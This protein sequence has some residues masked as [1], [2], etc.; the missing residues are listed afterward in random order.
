MPLLVLTDPGAATH[1][2]QL[3]GFVEVR[4]EGI[5]W[6]PNPTVPGS[7]VAILL[8]NPEQAGPLVIRVKLPSGVRVMPHTH[9]E[10]RTYTVLTGEWRLG[11]GSEFDASQLRT[12]PAGSVYRLPARVVHFQGTGAVETVIQIESI[13]P[14]STDFIVPPKR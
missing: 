11:F 13:G 4:P 8:G 6:R 12:Y 14:S 10:A 1:P 9:R 3:A 2:P 5:K 7:E